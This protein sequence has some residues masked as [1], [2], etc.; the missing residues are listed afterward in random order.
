MGSCWQN[1]IGACIF[2]WSAWIHTDRL[3]LP[4][5][6]QVPHVNPLCIVMHRHAVTV[7]KKVLPLFIDTQCLYV[8]RHCFYMSVLVMNEGIRMGMPI[9][10]SRFFKILVVSETEPIFLRLLLIFFFFFFYFY[11]IAIYVLLLKLQAK[12]M[13]QVGPHAHLQTISSF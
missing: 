4:I 11:F 3:R 6:I 2:T 5:C 13:N 10:K 12:C 1:A 7:Y 9:S 8:Y